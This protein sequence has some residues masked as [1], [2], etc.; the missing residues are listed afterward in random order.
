MGQFDAALISYRRVAELKPDSAGAH[1][2]LGNVFMMIG[3]YE[4][5]LAS[6]RR[7][8]EIE[9]DFA[10][11]HNNLGN[12]LMVL[13]QYDS[14]LA[15]YHRAL[16]IDPECDEALLG[17]SRLCM[18]NGEM[19]EAEETVKKILEV[20]PNNLEARIQLTSVRKTQAGDENLAALLKMEEDARNGRV[21]MPYQDAISLH[22]TL[23]NCFD[24][25]GDHDR[26]FLHFIEG[27][28][29]K[30]ATFEYDAAQMTKQFD[31]VIRVFDQA[32]IE[33]LRG[34]GSLSNVPI[35]VLGMPRSGTTLTEQII[36]SH[37]EV[38]GAGELDDLLLIALRDVAG[39]TGFPDN[40]RALD[41]ANLAKWADEYVACLRQ[42]APDA[43]HITDKMPN[44]FW[45]IGLIH[46]MLPNAKIIHVNRNPVDTCLSC[47]TKMFSA[48]M[49]QTYD[50]AELGRYYV[51][52]A[53]LM[54]HWRKVLPAGAFLDVQYEDIVA[55]QE[56]Q[57]RHIIDFCGL[58]WND[59]CID[60]HKLKR[61]VGSA[62]MMQVRQP[63]YKS[64]VERWRSYEKYL[65]PLLD[66][67]GDLAPKRN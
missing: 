48:V 51:D 23:G 18:I 2:N 50:L 55:D 34:G 58:E 4:S 64:S 53:R 43:R 49:M 66:A 42:H 63:I 27:C 30:R 14:A 59:A 17:V 39:T 37:P 8:V 24:D 19:K 47:F 57:A 56:T 32:T 25:L 45:L 36:A 60:F 29:L 65:G 41:Q 40:I 31:S 33:R 38:H 9:P 21:L 6:C 16:K 28:K 22:F 54:E 62:S 35:F 52:Y 67:L 13:G 15:S 26:A 5:A 10:M 46:V 7:A 1:I 12:V 3:Q 11:A 20:N 44:N 61:S